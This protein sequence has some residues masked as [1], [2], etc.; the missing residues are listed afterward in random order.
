[1]NVGKVIFKITKSFSFTC[2]CSKFSEILQ[3]IS[4]V[5]REGS[6]QLSQAKGKKVIKHEEVL[7][8]NSC[9]NFSAK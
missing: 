3:S 5:L 2:I 9:L 8:L 6:I 4:S 7:L 1:M